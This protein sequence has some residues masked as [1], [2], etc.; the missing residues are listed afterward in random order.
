MH[1]VTVVATPQ[2]EMFLRQRLAGLRRMAARNATQKEMA[3]ELGLSQSNVSKLLIAHGIPH[4]KRGSV[5][6]QTTNHA[7]MKTGPI[8]A[9]RTERLKRRISSDALGARAGVAGQSIRRWERGTADPSMA[10]FVAW[11][12]ALGMELPAWFESQQ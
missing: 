10:N 12:Q 1:I 8:A 3:Q 6:G 11:A 2:R 7:H 9:L 4:R 5:V